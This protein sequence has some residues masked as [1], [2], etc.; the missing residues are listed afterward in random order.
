M[1]LQQL[2]RGT[3][4]VSQHARSCSQHRTR[5]AWL[6]IWGPCHTTLMRWKAC[7]TF[8]ASGLTDGWLQAAM[9]SLDGILAAQ[10]PIL[11]DMLTQ[12]QVRKVPGVSMLP[13][14]SCST[15]LNVT[16]DQTQPGG[17]QAILL[18]EH[19]PGFHQQACSNK[20]CKQLLR[21]PCTSAMHSMEANM[22]IHV[23]CLRVPLMYWP[24]PCCRAQCSCAHTALLYTSCC[25]A[26]SCKPLH[27]QRLRPASD[28]APASH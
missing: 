27:V 20:C 21:Q 22:Q 4:H 7:S 16:R 12:A 13:K 5:E 2:G 11:K 24:T 25:A 19:V 14:V 1:G 26:S 18:A 3:P 28:R 10:S 17:H 8:A 23:C 15:S 9:V 6:P